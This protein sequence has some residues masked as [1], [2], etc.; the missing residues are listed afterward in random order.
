MV[1]PTGSG[2]SLSYVAQAMLTGHRT[3][4]LTSTK[5]LQQQLGTDFASVGLADVRGGNAYT[6]LA[7]E[8]DGPLH[9]LR[10]R[11]RLGPQGCDHGPCRAHVSCPL[12][13]AG[14][15]HYD[16]VRQ[17]QQ[18]Q[19][20]VTNYSY[21][22]TK[23]RYTDPRSPTGLGVF[24][25]LVLDEA[26][27]ADKELAAFLAVTLTPRDQS[28]LRTNPMPIDQA[29]ARYRGWA[30][31]ELQ[32][33]R[34]QAHK[35]EQGIR[36]A[37][38]EGRRPSRDDVHEYRQLSQVIEKLEML[39]RFDNDWI[40][41]KVGNEYRYG[42]SN[43]APW[44]ESLL[45]RGIENIVL[46]SATVTQRTAEFLGVNADS[47]DVIA[48]PSTFPARR[49]PV[50]IIPAAQ[51]RHRISEAELDVWLSRI[52]YIIGKRLDRKGIIHTTSYDRAQWIMARSKHAAHMM[53]HDSRTTRSTIERFRR[54]DAP[55]ILVSP[56]VT[57]GYDFPGDDCRYTIICKV[58]F[59]S[60]KDKFV[61]ARKKLDGDY[62]SYVAAQ[63]LVQS[64]GRAVR[65]G[66]DW[67]ESFIVDK[68]AVWFL[69][70]YKHFTP[71]WFQETVSIPGPIPDPPPLEG[72]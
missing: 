38:R 1:L 52:D 72:P 63:T 27:A 64:A 15:L 29:P 33:L 2:K 40:Y 46:T 18:S 36:A 47:M 22:L 43:P 12:Y 5:A 26:H 42:P 32:H 48:Y 21:W 54:A 61:A 37:Q 9:D 67:A 20:V 30:D 68:Q 66:N 34:Q 59:P 31:M 25:R 62:P 7:L 49:R 71:L 45:F 57:T 4:I 70:K 28:M 58:P 6:C 60:V 23:N 10:D 69:R 16:A 44:A 50:Y 3:A 55:A 17:A 24:D 19:I 14:C 39:G 53:S 51:M 65:S 35:L 13:E 56:S 8:P 11:S 41:D